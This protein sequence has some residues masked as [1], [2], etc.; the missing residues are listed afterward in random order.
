MNY[1][2]YYKVLGVSRSASEDEIKKA[3]RKLAQKYHPDKNPDDSNAEQKFKQANEAY[4]VLSDASKRK[5]YDRFGHQWEKHAQSGGRP[6]DFWGNWAGGRGGHGGGFG[7]G[8]RRNLT[9]EEI[10]QMLGGMGGNSGYSS[11]FD[12]LFGGQSGMGSGMGGNMRSGMGGSA[13]A[14]PQP[15]SAE[16]TISLNEAYRGGT[17]ML[18]SQNG[19]RFEVTIPPG[20]DNGSKI[21]MR[22]VGHQGDIVLSIKVQPHNRFSREGDN[23]R[24]KV[25]IDLYTILLGGEA[26]IPTLDRPVVLAIPAGTPNGKTFRLKG[27]GMPNLKDKKQHGDLYAEL[28]ITLPTALSEKERA[29][30]EELRALQ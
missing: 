24:V 4:T 26:E 18:N 7:G 9:P 11:F 23:L 8:Q 2:D 29:L 17:R 1:Q 25:P 5:Q 10:E 15:T 6:E 28:D 13:R 14:R 22:D 30:F 16:V 20:V 12:A 19:V 3:F 21:R 27:L